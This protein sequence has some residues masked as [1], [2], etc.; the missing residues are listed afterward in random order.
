MIEPI[1][2]WG[3]RA[4]DAVLAAILLAIVLITLAQVLWRYVIGASFTWS[5]EV[6]LML[7]AWLIALAAIK[8][9]H[10]RIGLVVSK[11]PAEWQVAL[12]AFRCVFSLVMLAILGWFGWKMVELTSFDFH[13]ELN[14]LSR[15]WLFMS[16]CAATIPWGIV[17]LARTYLTITALRQD[18]G[19]K[20]GLLPMTE[21]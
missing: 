13:V 3:E 9:Q 1:A 19:D 4:L 10:L 12:Y 8:A 11:L 14:W 21:H 15:K 6:N 7:W 17:V 16:I 2:K 5:E 20:T 18:P